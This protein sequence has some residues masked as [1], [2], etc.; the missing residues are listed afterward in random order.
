MTEAQGR[1]WSIET[2]SAK[3][4]RPSSL[5]PTLSASHSYP[6]FDSVRSNG[7]AGGGGGG[8]GMTSGYSYSSNTTS[9]EDSLGDSGNR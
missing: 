8:S 6:T 4:Y 7:G 1:S 3:N 5:Q 2:S 9:M